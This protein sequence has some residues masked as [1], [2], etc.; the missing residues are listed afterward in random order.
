MKKFWKK[1]RVL[2]IVAIVAVLIVLASVMRS[3]T[4]NGAD[5]HAGH[6]HAAGD[7]HTDTQ[8]SADPHAGH[9]HADYDIGK[10][11]AVTS[12]ANGTFSVSATSPHNEKILICDGLTSKPACAKINNSVLLVGDTSNPTIS[13]RWAIF[14]NGM[15]NKVSPRYDGCLA[16][17][18]TTVAVGTNNGAVIEVKDAFTG[19][20]HSKT[21]LPGA[22]SVDGRNIIQKT[23][24]DQN[25]DLI[26]TYW[27][28]EQ[29]KTHTV[30]MPRN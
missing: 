1:H 14:C 12:N 8:N 6:N 9:N 20:L 21:A 24:W 13:A 30:A 18:G 19:V 5:P 16:T 25:G 22:S 27:A 2:I 28:G 15:N 7:S 4:T 10:S 11:Y 26:V 23:A 29:V 17:Q 3:M